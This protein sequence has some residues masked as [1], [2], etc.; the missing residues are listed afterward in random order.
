MPRINKNNFK[1]NK[2]M[3]NISEQNVYDYK[4]LTSPLVNIAFNTFYKNKNNHGKFMEQ[5]MNKQSSESTRIR[6]IDI[7]CENDNTGLDN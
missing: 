6:K 5:L 2:I 4:P 7:S 3:Y 1:D